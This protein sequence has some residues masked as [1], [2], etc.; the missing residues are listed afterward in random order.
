MVLLRI[1]GIKANNI[2][3]VTGVHKFVYRPR[4]LGVKK[5]FTRPDKWVVQF[6]TKHIC[7][8]TDFTQAV[9]RRLEEEIKGNMFPDI[10]VS[11][12]YQYLK[13]NCLLKRVTYA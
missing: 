3:G 5:R 1:N 6:R 10:T 9:I 2:S 7:I 13:R 11:S 12:A 4:K 8:C